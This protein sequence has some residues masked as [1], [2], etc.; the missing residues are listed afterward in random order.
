MIRTQ[1]HKRPRAAQGF[2]M[3]E[4]L[5]AMLLIAL[6]MLGSAATQINALK[7]QKSA[8]NRTLAIALVGE[9]SERIEANLAAAKNGNYALATTSSPVASSTDC[10]SVF[11]TPA[12]MASFDL[13]QWS[14]RVASTLP[15]INLSVVQGVSA[16]GLVT[17]TIT[18]NWN[19]RRGRE[20]Y[21]T[22]GETEVLSYVLVKTVR[23]VSS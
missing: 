10:T 21:A 5:I 15:L 14:G 13:A 1:A 6:W 20:T 2:A 17:Y 11:C 16:S 9:L 3:I 7:F 12:Q 8:E 19:E 18:V 22:T 4:A 23:N